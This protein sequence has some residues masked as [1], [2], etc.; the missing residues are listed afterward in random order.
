[1]FLDLLGGVLLGNNSNKILPPSLPANPS[2]QSR[3]KH[4]PIDGTQRN[5][6]ECQ[7]AGNRKTCNVVTHVTQRGV[8]ALPAQEPRDCPI[9]HFTPVIT[10]VVRTPSHHADRYFRHRG[11]LHLK[12]NTT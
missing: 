12:A 3:S 10:L 2:S 5:Q 1:M 6:R 7:T 9:A 4:D 8:T 11:A